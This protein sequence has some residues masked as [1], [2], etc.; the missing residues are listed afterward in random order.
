[1]PQISSGKIVLILLIFIGL[2]FVLKQSSFLRSIGYD[3]VPDTYVILDEHTN[4]WHGLS[5]RKSGVPTAWSNL[6]AYKGGS[7]GDVKEL[8]LSV[9]E[10]RMPNLAN[11]SSYPKPVYVLHP[12][13]LGTGKTLKKVGFVQPYLDH[14]PL[15][16]LVLSAS[17][18]SNVKNFS[19]LLPDDFRRASLWLGVVSGI[20]IFVLGWQVSKNP[21]VGLISAAIYGTVPTFN[22][23]SRYAL[24]ENVLNP[25]MLITLNLLV[26]AKKLT[27]SEGKKASLIN[28]LLIVAGVFAGMAALVKVIGWFV[29]VAGVALL[30]YW[31]VS[32]KKISLFA[33]PAI[34]TGLLYFAW[35]FYLDPKLF[36][37]IFFY[38]GLE[39]GFIGS[40]NFLTTLGGVSIANFPFDGW[41][42]GG[43]I[44]LG[45]L[46]GK[47]EYALLIVTA[48]VYLVAALFL[49][50]ANY[51]WYYM[52][53]IPLM[54][55]AIALL[56]WRVT[57]Q[58]TLLQILIFFLIFFSSSFYWGYG[59]FQADK[60]STNYQQPYFLYRIF[61]II[62]AVAGLVS[63]FLDKLKQRRIIL[64]VW[65]VFMMVV[66]YQLWK[67]NNQSILYILSHWGKYPS[68]FTPGT[69]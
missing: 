37:N 33:V 51:P 41:W 7:G 38:Q 43:F 25:V 65:F 13:Y 58:P 68:L 8:N 4:V 23:L 2:F 40:L 55:V 27:E 42:L 66:T 64:A 49:G 35:G 31:G 54:C 46:I 48:I 29:L 11:F 1:M 45:F 52:P 3:Q 47:K 69:F 60:L 61:L 26:F 53:L 12:V 9:S 21:F 5:I 20:L 28:G 24:L 62:F 67:W 32:K 56:L 57:T 63:I 10:G 34:L 22:L 50:G 17:V 39:R 15:G 30:L 6:A 59:V 44:A 36:V 18:K 16:A 19:D 14:P